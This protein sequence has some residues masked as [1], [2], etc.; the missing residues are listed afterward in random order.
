MA[1]E[2]MS[3]TP[4]FNITAGGEIPIYAE[5]MFFGEYDTDATGSL[6]INAADGT[7]GEFTV[8]N[9]LIAPNAGRTSMTV[10]VYSVD[11]NTVEVL[12]D[13]KSFTEFET[14]ITYSKARYAEPVVLLFQPGDYTTG[15]GLFAFQK[16]DSWVNGIKYTS[17]VRADK[18]R[19]VD[20]EFI[21][22]QQS[23][24]VHVDNMEFYR[25][26]GSLGPML[27]DAAYL[28]HDWKVTFCTFKG[29][30][31]T[32]AQLADTTYPAG[33]FYKSA[34]LVIDNVGAIVEDNTFENVFYASA[35]LLDGAVSFQRNTCNY[36][37]LDGFRFI[38]A[39][40]R[41]D[42]SFKEIKDNVAM[43]PFG[44]ADEAGGTPHPDGF[45]FINE[46]GHIAAGVEYLEMTGN[47]SFAGAATRN[48]SAQACF[49]KT[50]IENSQ[51]AYNVFAT[52]TEAAGLYLGEDGTPANVS[53]INN[54]IIDGDFGAVSVTLR[55]H[56]IDGEIITL[57]NLTW[58]A[59]DNTSPAATGVVTSVN[60][61]TDMITNGYL[62]QLAGP[63]T[64][65]TLAEA[66]T[67]FAAKSGSSADTNAQGA[68]TVAGE[69]R[70]VVLVPY[71][72]DAP[73]AAEVS[74]DIDVIHPADPRSVGVAI[75]S[76]DMR[77]R[78]NAGAWT[79]VIGHISG[80]DIIAAG[81]GTHD[82]QVRAVNS[83]HAGFWSDSDT[84]VIA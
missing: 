68:L 40:N 39:D 60:D 54:T 52:R 69:F 5:S 49:V 34:G 12:A 72:P 80:G 62:S 42:A 73:T 67:Q 32:P 37:W 24:Y 1:L 46:G 20:M 8:L 11:G 70:T 74:G 2:T 41:G 63:A 56:S 53:S 19:I 77:H 59:F 18:A 84:V 76:W 22:N 35:I 82:I 45:Q 71:K 36:Y 79:E 27:E 48:N 31:L 21:G 30:A 25:T 43:N 55:M 78:T 66:M 7:Y 13:A 16:R 14:A 23:R 33:G 75:T 44:R 3:R 38:M 28:T 50:D 10:G 83:L 64:P 81:S 57:N 9:K 4:T 47:V 58:K 15:T 51:F 61:Y 26:D 6:S 65:T 17:A 29:E